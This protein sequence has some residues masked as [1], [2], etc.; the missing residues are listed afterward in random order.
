MLAIY[1]VTIFQFQHLAGCRV[2]LVKSN[3]EMIVDLV[4]FACLNSL[5]FLILGLFTKFR[6][7][8][9]LFSFSSA[10]IIILFA[11]FLNLRICPL[12]EIGKK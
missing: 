10:I 3:I 1:P 12:C 8:E 2:L 9:F 4:I 11:R 6:I 5:E 7:C